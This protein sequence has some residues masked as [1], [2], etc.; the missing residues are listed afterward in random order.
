MVN[1]FSQG[2]PSTTI[3]TVNIGVPRG[4][5]VTGYRVRWERVRLVAVPPGVQL[6]RVFAYPPGPG[7]G[8]MDGNI[9]E[10]CPGSKPYP[11]TAAVV[12]SHA[13]MQWN[14]VVALTFTKPGRYHLRRVKIFYVTDGHHG[15]QYQDLNTT[16]VISSP[17]KGAKPR[18][19]GC[20]P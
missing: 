18:F 9:F 14:V 16:M 13:Q 7:V 17:R 8:I 12:P 1:G 6:E 3:D 11:L 15:W 20:I 19:D 10:N 4:Q 2:G 5:N